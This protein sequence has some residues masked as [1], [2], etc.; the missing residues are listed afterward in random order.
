MFKSWAQFTDTMLVFIFG[1][2]IMEILSLALVSSLDD[3]F[4]FKILG[5]ISVTVLGLIFGALRLVDYLS[6]RK[7]EKIIEQNEKLASEMKVERER[8]LQ[9]ID[10]NERVIRKLQGK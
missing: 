5:N 4:N 2:N 1:Y 9:Q 10:E 6:K 3:I 7:T 8:R